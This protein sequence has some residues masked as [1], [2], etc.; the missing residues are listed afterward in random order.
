MADQHYFETTE[1]ERWNHPGRVRARFNKRFV[2]SEMRKQKEIENNRMAAAQIRNMIAALERAVISLD[3]S[4]DTVLERSPV[5]DPCNFAYPVA[6]RA[7]GAR[8]DNIQGT[9]AVLSRQLAKINE[10][11]EGNG[12]TIVKTTMTTPMPASR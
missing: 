11:L 8:R 4:I 10:S 12:V 2:R 1:T 6:A 9:I 7:M 5:L 3:G